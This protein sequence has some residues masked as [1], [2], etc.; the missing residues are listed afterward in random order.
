MR[1]NVRAISKVPNDYG[2][3]NAHEVEDTGVIATLGFQ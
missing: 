3:T 2:N 1:E